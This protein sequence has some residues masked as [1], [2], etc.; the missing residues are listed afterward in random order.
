MNVD[1]LLA[2]RERTI[3]LLHSY[4]PWALSSVWLEPAPYKGEIGGS[5]PPA[6]TKF[7]LPWA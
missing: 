5:N 6:P 7:I 3:E 1:V 4:Q 2:A